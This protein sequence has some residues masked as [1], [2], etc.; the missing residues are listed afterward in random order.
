MYRKSPNLPIDIAFGLPVN[1]DS[2]PGAVGK[3][4][5]QMQEVYELASKCSKKSAA[6]G[7]NHHDQKVHVATLMPGDRVLV[8]NLSERGRPSKIRSYREDKINLVLERKGNSP[9]YDVKAEDEKGLSTQSHLGRSCRELHLPA[10]PE[11]Q[12]RK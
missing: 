3:W 12:D 8:W 7:K 10:T 6:P 1:Y 2:A 5:L 9:V 11:R 4:K